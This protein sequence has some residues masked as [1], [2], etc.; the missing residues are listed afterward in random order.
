MSSS[1]ELSTAGARTAYLPNAFPAQFED[2]ESTDFD[3]PAY[4]NL[5]NCLSGVAAIFDRHV[6]QAGAIRSDSELRGLSRSARQERISEGIAGIRVETIKDIKHLEQI[7]TAAGQQAVKLDTI[8]TAPNASGPAAA[9][10]I[11]RHQALP[12][13]GQVAV[14]HDLSHQAAAATSPTER[15]AAREYLSALGGADPSD[16]LLDETSRKLVNKAL[17]RSKDGAKYTHARHLAWRHGQSRNPR[18]RSRAD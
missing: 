3:D 1:Y 2:R 10:I 18:S 5:R 16:H 4:D 11:N 9:E 7:A 14:I 13:D 12:R 15:A 6:R 17:A 8:L